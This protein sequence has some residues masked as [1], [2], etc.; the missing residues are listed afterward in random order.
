MNLFFVWYLSIFALL[1]FI[2]GATLTLHALSQ[3]LGI[4]NALLR[5]KTALHNPSHS[6]PSQ[7]TQILVR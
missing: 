4:K 7:P 2:L 1:L 3:L 6:I 5:L